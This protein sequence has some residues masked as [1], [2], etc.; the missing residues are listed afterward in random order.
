M[1]GLRPSLPLFN[2]MEIYQII[3]LDCRIKENRKRL[4]SEVMN[5]TKLDR[6]PTL[7]KLEKMVTSVG[8]K[9]NMSVQYIQQS[10]DGIAMSVRVGESY[11]MFACRS[12][13]EAMCKIL[14][15]IKAYKDFRKKKVK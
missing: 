7:Q 12:Y 15:Y 9:Y 11:Q 2:A 14:L 8:K 3:N 10:A 13:Y 4:L 1:G 5:A 6:K